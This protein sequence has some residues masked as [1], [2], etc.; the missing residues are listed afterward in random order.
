MTAAVFYLNG[1]ITVTENVLNVLGYLPKNFFPRFS[2]QA[3]LWRQRLGILQVIIGVALA[4]LGFI[5]DWFDPQAKAHRTLSFFQK[6]IS[7]GLLHLNHGI[8]NIFR[9]FLEKKE[10]GLLTFAY[11]FYGRKFLPA[12]APAFDLQGRLF[13]YI[14]CQL[15]CMQ[16]VT[17]FPPQFLF[18]Q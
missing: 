8:F 1:L 13:T 6:M 2:A 14:R 17:L 12:L 5:L 3:P 10:F 16:V 18:K 15:D 4:A 7:L 11:D 9:S